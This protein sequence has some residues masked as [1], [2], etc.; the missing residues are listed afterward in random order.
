V[1]RIEGWPGI[2]LAGV[3]NSN[4]RDAHRIFEENIMQHRMKEWL[5]G[6]FG[7]GTVASLATSIAASALGQAEN[8]NAVAPV[9][10]VSHI[11]FGDRAAWQNSATAQYTLTGLALN[12][13]AVTAW[14]GLHESWFGQQD[15]E[16]P[17]FGKALVGGA[18]VAAIAYVTDYHVVPK[19]LTPGFEKRLSNAPLF[20]IYATLAISLAVGS[21]L[22]R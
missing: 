7:T 1:P 20:G 11:I 15:E 2:V 4:G 14:A 8:G 18:V 22:K 16:K 9:N 13:A 21:L 3:S 17:S 19:R 12:S 5:A 6:T 10:A